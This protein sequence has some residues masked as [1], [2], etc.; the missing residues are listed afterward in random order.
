LGNPIRPRQKTPLKGAP[1]LFLRKK[2]P[3]RL[4]ESHHKLCSDEEKESSRGG[5][6][7]QE[8]FVGADFAA[9]KHAVEKNELLLPAGEKHHPRHTMGEPL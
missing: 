4:P 6:E 8:L 7:T 2:L 3:Q 1:H 9:D 5:R